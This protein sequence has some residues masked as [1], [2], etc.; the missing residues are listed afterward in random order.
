VVATAR[1]LLDSNVVSEAVRPAPR[2][3]V[4]AAI[5]LH[6]G[7]LAIAATTWAEL[8]FGVERLAA[9]RRKAELHR[10]LQDGVLPNFA[11]F[12]FD[13]EAASWHGK[14]RARLQAAG[15]PAPFEDGQIA[16]IAATRGLVVVTENVRHFAHFQGVAVVNWCA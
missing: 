15:T 6:R 4:L 12:A 11:V 2:P 10:F 1:F 5:A 14:E 13:A 3:A 8:V 9:G 16:A 7:T